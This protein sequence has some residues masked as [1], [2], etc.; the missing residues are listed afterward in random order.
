LPTASKLNALNKSRVNASR[1]KI[2]T[3]MMLTEIICRLR[4]A[5]APSSIAA[6]ICRIRAFPGDCAKINLIK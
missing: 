1:T 4:Y 2:T 6:A 5:F 3:A